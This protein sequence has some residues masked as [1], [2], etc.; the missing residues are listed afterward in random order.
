[1]NVIRYCSTKWNPVYVSHLC[2]G[3]YVTALVWVI[4]MVNVCVYQ[5]DINYV[6][7]I[8]MFL[9]LHLVND[10]GYYIWLWHMDDHYH[11]KLMVHSDLVDETW[12]TWL[13]ILNLITNRIWQKKL[14]FVVSIIVLCLY[15]SKKHSY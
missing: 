15:I 10:T 4:W 7:V 9:F 3:L 1:M 2:I 6:H 13:C 8:W 14:I 12:F 5:I 11:V